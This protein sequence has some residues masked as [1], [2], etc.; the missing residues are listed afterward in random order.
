MSKPRQKKIDADQKDVLILFAFILGLPIASYAFHFVYVYVSAVAFSGSTGVAWREHLVAFSVG[1]T[2]LN[3]V[4]MSVAMV[5]AAVG[6]VRPG[7][8]I[9][10]VLGCIAGAVAP[11]VPG[12]TFNIFISS[13]E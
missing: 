11:T 6:K 8:V 1:L 9:G 3:V 4:A 10:L 5:S 7:L 2:A 13:S 12:F